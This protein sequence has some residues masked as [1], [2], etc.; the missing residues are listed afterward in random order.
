MTVRRFEEHQPTIDGSAWI[1]PSAEVIGE[2]IIG[3]ESSVWPMSVLRG[4]IHFIRIGAR[5]NI[6]DATIVH[7]THDSRFAPGGHGVVI[8]DGVTIG[9]RVVLH[10]CTVEDRCLIGMGATVM[11][12]ARIRSGAMVGAGS[13]VTPGKELEGG[14]LW[15]G[16]P[17]RKV[18][19]L[20]VEEREYLDYSAEHYVRLMRRHRA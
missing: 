9:H 1:H 18:R 16:A 17:A 15:L 5:T 3:P 14:H 12:G 13:L 7:V 6:Q 11:D 2:V 8:G 4:D 10:G 19:P 20:T